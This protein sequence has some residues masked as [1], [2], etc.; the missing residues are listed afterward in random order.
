MNYDRK[1]EADPRQ[2][3]E[4]A[5]G[6]LKTLGIDAEETWKKNSAADGAPCHAFSVRLHADDYDMSTNGKGSSRSYA[7]ASAYGEFMERLENMFLLPLERVSQEA[8][9]EGGFLLFPDERLLTPDEVCRAEDA[10]SQGVVADYYRGSFLLECGPKEQMRVVADY[11]RG[12]LSAEEK[13]IAWPFYSVKEERVVDIWQHYI[14]PQGS[15]GMCAGNTPQE[16]LVQGLSEIFERYAIA[17]ILEGK[18][19]PPDIPQEEYLCFDTLRA[20]ISEIEAM[21]PYRI[22]VKDWSLGK[23][24]PVCAAVLMDTGKQR[25]RASFGSHP[26]RP[27]AIERCLTELLQGYDPADSRQSDARLI[28][29]SRDCTKIDPHVNLLNMYSNG[30]GV[31]PYG[32]FTDLPTYACAPAWDVSGEDNRQMLERYVSLALTLSDDILIRD[33]SYLGFPAYMIL[34]PGVS[35]P[36][37]TRQILR[38][39]NAYA[40]LF[41]LKQYR[42]SRDERMLNVL[43]AGLN[44]WENR[45]ARQALP[46]PVYHLKAAVMLMLGRL[47]ELPAYLEQV[48]P[49]IVPQEERAEM[50]AL[51]LAVRLKHEGTAEERIERL[52][53]AFY[54]AK[55]WNTLRTCWLCE[56]P[57][58]AL[59]SSMADNGKADEACS[60]LLIR[61]KRQF[62]RTP[63]SQQSLRTLFYP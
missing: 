35:H 44:M 16:A 15:T 22:L 12:S 47:Q 26:S 58:D 19:V 52:I 59:L 7:L 63:V 9:A 34:I 60:A 56:N 10:F 23:D 33:V 28:P 24:L 32:F 54:S 48:L 62:S 6:I 11:K 39:K 21:G 37:I 29:I 61:I 38:R 57:L 49:T 2:T 36:R 14:W 50:S 20:I 4:K 18:A 42:E 41:S 27:V 45:S 46:I 13:L 30:M 3:V 1:K 8:M 17:Q 55:V 43:L 51:A 25:Y 53:S 40:S 5:R 31:L